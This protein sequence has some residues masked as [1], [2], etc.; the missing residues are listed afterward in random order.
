MLQLIIIEIKIVSG[1]DCGG[2][3]SKTYVAIFI[4]EKW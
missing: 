4:V 3:Q 1:D 2:Y